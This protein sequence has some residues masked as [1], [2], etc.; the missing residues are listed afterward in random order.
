MIRPPQVPSSTPDGDWRSGEPLSPTHRDPESQRV[1]SARLERRSVRLGFIPLTDCAPLVVAQEKGYFRRHG[2]E[3]ELIR[4]SSWSSIRDK[5]AIGD[6][7][8][9]HMLAPMAIASTLGLGS[10]RSPV[11]TAMSLGLN[12]NAI[13]VSNELHEAM[14]SKEPPAGPSIAG[15]A[16]ALAA[17]VADRRDAGLPPL[18]FG[19]VFPFSCHNYELRFWLASAGIDPDRD[20]RLEGVPPPRMVERI[21]R[22]AID[23]FCV[24]EPWNSLCVQRGLGRVVLTKHDLWNNS[25]EKVLGVR[26]DW[27]EHN[28]ATHQA[29]VRAVLEAAASLDEAQGRAEAV[30]LLA[31]PHLIDVPE[32]ALAPGLMGEFGMGLG[33][34]PRSLPDFL[35]FHRYA[36]NFPWRSHALWVLTQMVRWGQLDRAIHLRSV[37]ERVYLPEA[38]RRAARQ[39]GLPSPSIDDKLEGLHGAGW[40]CAGSPSRIAL[41]PDLFLDGTAFDPSRPLDYVQRFAL[42]AGADEGW[43]AM[44]A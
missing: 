35:V 19:V 17:V 2:L 5:V 24:G 31:G 6:L 32:S 11:V 33:E 8:G 27:A 12:G 41:G 16:A 44:N 7:D 10:F 3:V 1:G 38:Y 28:P 18:R 9:A 43:L 34:A 39:L 40:W 4:E 26:E 25:P 37:A 30:G 23:G 20:V 22:G 15:S 42:G 36:A 14:A 13:T 29:L 21:E